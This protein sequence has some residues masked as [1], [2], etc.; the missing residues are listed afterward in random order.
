L[1]EFHFELILSPLCLTPAHTHN[2]V[3]ISG[4]QKS[5]SVLVR[6]LQN[7]GCL[8]QILLVLTSP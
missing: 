5:G 1:N 7:I 2:A 8:V 4:L 3:T 6:I